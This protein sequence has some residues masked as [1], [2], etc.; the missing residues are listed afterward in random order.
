MCSVIVSLG[1]CM[2]LSLCGFQ[3]NNR[4]FRNSVLAAFAEIVC[5]CIIFGHFR[6]IAKSD[7]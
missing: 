5:V 7:Y 3:T 2:F 4:I 1:L 6:K